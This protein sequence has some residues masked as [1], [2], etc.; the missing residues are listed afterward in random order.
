MSR[1]LDFQKTY[2]NLKNVK[3]MTCIVGLEA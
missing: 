2:K 1:F 3:V